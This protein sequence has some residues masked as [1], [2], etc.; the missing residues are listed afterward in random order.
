MAEQTITLDQESVQHMRRVAARAR[1]QAKLDQ[2]NEKN[3]SA[4][5]DSVER[6]DCVTKEQFVKAYEARGKGADIT[7]TKERMIERYLD[8]R[9]ILGEAQTDLVQML[10]DDLL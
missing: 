1:Q 10:T 7:R 6:G 9:A 4:L 2:L 5:C 3:V 8:A